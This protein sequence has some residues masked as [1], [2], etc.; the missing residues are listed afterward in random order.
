MK[1]ALYRIDNLKIIFVKYKFQNTVRD[2]NDENETHFNVLK[3]HVIIYY[4]TFIQL[5]NSAQNFDTVYKKVTHKFLLKIFFVMTN[6]VND[7][8]IQILKYNVQR[9]NM[10]VMQDV[11]HYLKIKTKF[12]IKKQFDVWIIK[13]CQD[14]I[15]LMNFLNTLNR[16]AL[17]QLKQSQ[18]H[19]R[20][21]KN[22]L[23]LFN[24]IVWNS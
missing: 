20:K 13:V 12:K 18:K 2:G 15:K 22:L 10:I 5:Y 3:L 24:S 9:Y 4:V 14:L 23:Q 19:Y 11:I 8:K 1:H 7:W 6:K 16:V 21:T 17:C